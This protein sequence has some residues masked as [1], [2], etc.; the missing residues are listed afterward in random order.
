[1]LPLCIFCDNESGSEEH[2]W[3]AWMHRLMKFGA[4]RVQEGISTETIEADPE[5]TINTVC[6]TCNNTW[7]SQLEEKNIPSVRPMMQ[8]QPT[9]I[10]PGRQR[11]LTEWA[12]KTAMV[13]ESIKPRLGNEKFY[14]EAERVNM[15]LTR[16]IPERTR[17][18]IGALTE[19]HLGSFGTDLAIFGNN[20]ST[21][22]GT[23]IASTIVV[24]HFV[25]QVVTQHAFPEFAAQDIPDIQPRAGDWGDML[26]ELY[27]KKQKKLNW[28]PKTSFTNGGPKGIAYLMHRWRIGQKVDQVKPLGDVCR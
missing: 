23:G 26:I 13:L 7:M 27:P 14:T 11:L 25:V 5:K 6:H 9:V 24:G 10:D 1:M 16:Q 12:V 17:I 18:W 19:A 22:I 28:P 2:L 21:R 20:G 15:R 3:A 8:N 4:I